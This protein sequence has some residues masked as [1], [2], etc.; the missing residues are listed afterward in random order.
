MPCSQVVTFVGGPT[1]GIVMKRPYPLDCKITCYVFRDG[2]P[3]SGAPGQAVQVDT[4]VYRLEQT[5][6][7]QYVYVCQE[8]R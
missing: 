5:A 2:P 1:D 3:E 8:T 6:T 7:G 4:F